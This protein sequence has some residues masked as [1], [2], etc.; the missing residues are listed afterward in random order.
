MT[1]RLAAKVYVFDACLSLLF[2][3]YEALDIPPIGSIFSFLLSIM[4]KVDEMSLF[5]ATVFIKIYV[6]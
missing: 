4:F 6:V 2:K 3:S 5:I 1:F